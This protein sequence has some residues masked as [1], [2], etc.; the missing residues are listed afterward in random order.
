MNVGCTGSCMSG[1]T[2][3]AA[4]AHLE[5]ADALHETQLIAGIAIAILAEPE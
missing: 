3:A 4:R 1:P 2:N 5:R